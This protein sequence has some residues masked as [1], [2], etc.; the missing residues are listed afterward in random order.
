[1]SNELQTEHKAQVVNLLCEGN[2][3]RSIE[4]ITGIH[5]DTVMRLGVRIGE[6]C[7]RILDEKLRNLN[8]G[9]IEIDEVWGFIGM[10]QKTAHR[11]NQAQLL[12]DWVMRGLCSLMLTHPAPTTFLYHEATIAIQRQ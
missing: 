5:R 6:G 8:C 12:S 9:R 1:M 11:T 10:K 3:I 2:S 4:R 7:Q